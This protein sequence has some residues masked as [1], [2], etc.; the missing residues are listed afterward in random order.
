MDLRLSLAQASPEERGAI[1]RLLGPQDHPSAEKPGRDR[2]LPALQAVQGRVGWLS[3][4]ALNYI[5]QRLDVPPAEAFGVASFYRML[6][7]TPRGP[8]MA[9]VCED[10]T[11]RL[12]GSEEICRALEKRLG[13]PASPHQPGAAPWQRSACLGQC[14]RAPA[15]LVVRAGQEPEDLILGNSDAGHVLA[16]VA[17]RSL[18]PPPEAA[19]RIPQLGRKDLRLLRRIGRVDPA[20]LSDYRAQGGYLALRRALEIG[21]REVI[22]QVAASR[23][24][25]RGGAA[26]PT[27][28]KWQAVAD[29]ADGPHYLVCNADE[30]EPGTFKD[31]V[32]IEED[33]FNLI[34][35]MSIAAFATGCQ[36]GYVYLRGEYPLAYRRLSQALDQAR[37]AGLL[38]N[39]IFG[40]DFQ[41]HLEIRRG[42][43]AYICG[44]ETALFNSIEGYRGEPRSK[45]P[46]PVTSGLF[47]KPTVINNVETLAN[48][49]DI[50]LEGGAAFAARGTAESTGTRLFCLSGAIQ[51]PGV[52][53]VP[54]GTTLG[55]LLQMAGSVP[56][57]RSLR[58]VLLGGAAGSFVGPTDLELP[59]SFEGT[60]SAG[61]TLGSGA[62]IVFDDTTNLNEVLLR[63]AAF[64]REESCGQ[65]VPCRVGTV[66]QEEALQDIL[67]AG[68]DT[69]P[70]AK[71]ELLSE[72]AQAMRDAS[73]C[74]LGQTAGAAVQSAL[75]KF[76]VPHGGAK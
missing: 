17:G 44:E 5:C 62:I 27:A 2:L 30:S 9:Y 3:E 63:L 51:R 50:V 39:R 7:L 72:I 23:L 68:G 75:A 52:Y 59:L 18:S 19:T 46:F 34:E 67:R 40:S 14:D 54:L 56:R 76:G 55:A 73:I 29:N 61:A 65:C 12:R 10:L 37:S 1:D 64:F 15:V 74:G 49:P 70:R 48:I 24:L 45:P 71:L 60:R 4:G 32:L 28:R 69:S 22:R 26:F 21:G 57:N 42:A 8:V 31:R 25:G 58:A 53:E 47:H 16:A 13:P 20:S 36:R 6:S 66:R 33:P 38:Q 43:G 35:A 41:F 11:C